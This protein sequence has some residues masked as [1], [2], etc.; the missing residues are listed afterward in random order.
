MKTCTR[1]LRE[2]DRSE[3]YAD[4]TPDGLRS[5]CKDC[6][7]ARVR[8][9][10]SANAEAYKESRREQWAAIPLE[11]KREWARLQRANS[12]EM[13]RLIQQRHRAAN[14]EKNR[15]R[16][17]INNAIRRG[18]LTRPDHCEWCNAAGGVGGGKAIEASHWD[19][20]KPYDVLWLC[21]P[22]HRERDRKTA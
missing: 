8:E 17:I 5:Q 1:C 10:R 22:C 13:R 14:P 16:N 9:W 7:N 19:Y 4:K 2:L 12:P 3:F 18:A 11:V 15:A 6:H 20:S 21:R